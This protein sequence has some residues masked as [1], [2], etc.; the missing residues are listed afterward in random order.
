MGPLCCT[1]FFG[2]VGAAVPCRW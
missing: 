1:Y 2:D